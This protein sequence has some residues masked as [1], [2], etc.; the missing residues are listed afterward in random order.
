MLTCEKQKRDEYQAN[1]NDKGIVYNKDLTKRTLTACVHI[2][3]LSQ[4]CQLVRQQ[5]VWTYNRQQITPPDYYRTLTP[6][7]VKTYPDSPN[8][9]MT[10]AAPCALHHFSV[11][12]KVLWPLLCA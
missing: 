3:R 10:A 6:R 7:S 11:V 5:M 9:V 2:L 4:L 8:W 12:R 1:A